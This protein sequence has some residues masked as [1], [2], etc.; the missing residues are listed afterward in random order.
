M[1]EVLARHLKCYTAIFLIMVLLFMICSPALAETKSS[2]KSTSSHK[3]R[4]L[5]VA[6]PS[7]PGMSE[8]DENGTHHGLVVDYL[9]EIAKYT[10]WEYEYVPIDDVLQ[11]F[12]DFKAGK[13][14][15]LGGQYYVNGL[16]NQYGYPDFNTGYSRSCLLARKNDRSIRSNDIESMNGKTIGV[17][18][19]AE[20]NI[21]RLKEFLTFNGIKCTIKEYSFEELGKDGTLY[22]YL[23]NGD[24]DLLLGNAQDRDN[25]L[26]LVVSYD[27]QP[28]YIVTTPDNKEVLDGLN[29]AMER[30]TDANPNFGKER[31]EANFHNTDV[32]I[33]L[34]DEEIQYVKGR[35]AVT[36]AV[37]KTWHPLFCNNI[38]DLHNG[39]VPD[40][41]EEINSFTGLK[42]EYV[43]ADS[44]G[45]AIKLVQQG[46]AEM[47]GFYL[48][49]ED[50][51]V[52]HK[53]ILSASYA[54]M[55]NLVVRNKSSNYPDQKLIGAVIDG[56]TLP[57][58]I[59]AVKV[60]SYTSIGKA[61]AAVNKGE[62]DFVYGLSSRLEQEIQQHHFTNLVPVTLADES[63]YACFA[64]A[65]PAETDLLTI[66]NK[67]VNSLS[68]EEKSSLL[69]QN[70]VSPGE[71]QLNLEELIYADP[72]AF[73]VVL[74]VVLIMIAGA[75]LLVTRSRMKAA[76]IQSNLERAEAESRAKGEF[77]SRMSHEIRTPMNAIVG[78]ADLT[79]MMNDVPVD[80]RENLSKIRSA[81][82][83]LLGLINDILDMSRIDS[84]MLSIAKEPFSLNQML[85]SLQSMMESEAQ[86]RG[87]L[88]I[89][90]KSVNEGVLLGDAIRLR[91][92]LINLLSNAFKFTPEGG[93]VLLRIAEN[94]RN[95]EDATY[96]FQVID[97][98]VGIA[99]EDQERIFSSFEQLGTSF[100]QSQG[101][102]L[103]L[104]I[105][106]NIVELM[107]GELQLQSEVGIGSEFYFNVTLPFGKP[108]ENGER[109][110][111]DRSLAGIKILLAEDNNLNAEIAM[112]LL[113]IKGAIVIRGEDG[114]RALDIFEKSQTDEYDVI[115]MDVQ[116]PNL[117]GLDAARAIRA[118]P[119]PDAA[120]IPIIAMTASSFQK[121]VDAAMEAG[122]TGFISKPLDVNYLYQT[123]TDSLK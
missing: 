70:L 15:L 122:M 91:Q 66:I 88:F 89:V 108:E 107:G 117:N 62:A 116:M 49:T 9:N 92:V 37:P 47:L 17:Y 19:K 98:G 48:G 109:A 36:V 102:G 111:L 16:E 4:V 45:D 72:V 11:M 52:Q 76:V 106:R 14:D 97:N 113:E 38:D 31:Y 83:Y 35:D 13:Y 84:G 25:D 43:Y 6:F 118:L 44:Y 20:E 33:Q 51:A 77:L 54:S 28:F 75:I 24:V 40:M 46:K 68:G 121:D 7:V 61:L 115:L 56:Q 22:A 71:S 67:A 55:N 120:T 57:S 114:K 39:L 12:E 112:R 2:G 53:L 21:R 78:L 93:K 8:T 64:Y 85:D 74:A 90:E 104:A 94:E 63:S 87:I 1:K 23:E 86:R 81:S 123:L 73:V 29:M 82:Q 50:E 41:L 27:S 96:C 30:I 3:S 105:S 80:V 100:S 119:R 101:T 79:G 5:K 95:D 34:T 26:R 42:F 32:D 10:G 18:E 65:Q 58:D 99:A 110:A 60:K 69:N 59:K 103:G